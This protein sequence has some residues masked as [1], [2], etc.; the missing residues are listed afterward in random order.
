VEVKMIKDLRYGLRMLFKHKAFT[1]VAVLSLGLGIGANTAIFSLID[2]VLLKMLPV[3]APEQLFILN[4]TGPDGSNPRFSYPAFRRMSDALPESSSLSAISSL[5]RLNAS[6]AGGQSESVRGQLVSG[7]WFQSLGVGAS[8]GR[9]LE[10]ADN[11]SQ[12]GHPVAVLSHSFWQNR[13]ANDSSVV[14]LSIILNGSPFTVVGV[15]SPEFFG[16]S[17][18]EVPDLWIPLMMQSD[19]RYSQNA[20]IS[21][22]DIR[23]PWIN[24]NRIEWLTLILRTGDTES[25]MSL[26]ARLDSVLRPDLE[27][28]AARTPEG[29]GRE[30]LLQQQ[31]RMEPG[32]KGLAGLRQIFSSPLKVLMAMVGLVLL[33]ACANVANLSLARATARRQ[34]IAIR[35]SVGASRS[36]LVRQLLTESL[37]LAIIGGAVGLLIAQWG[38]D[39]LL[40]MAS[41]GQ[42]PI[43]IE[44]KLDYR[45]LLFAAVVSGATA[46]L[47]GLAPALRATRVELASAMK[48]NTRSG[49]G[50]RPKLGKILVVAQV[51]LSLVLLAG[52]ALF[53]RSLQNLARVDPGFDQHRVVT[54]RIDPRAAGYREEQLPGL[55]RRL[56]DR[57]ESINGIQLAT[58]SL[59]SPASGSART[60]GIN[61]AGRPNRPEDDNS[62]QENYVGPNYFQIVGMPIVRGR[63]FGP[64]DHEK[65]PKVAVVNETMVRQF[66]NDANPIGRRFGYDAPPLDSDYEIVGVVRDAKIN[67]L[68]E[69]VRPMIYYLLAQHPGEFVRGLDVRT[70]GDPRQVVDQIRPAIAEID[71]NLPVR[72]IMTLADQVDRTL[73][74]EKLLARL[75]GFFS[76]L[77]VGL[78]CIG[79]YGV[80]SYTV[81]RRTGEIGIRVALGASRLKVLWMVMREALILVAIGVA[82]GLP[83]ALAAAPMADTLVFGLEPSDPE[84]LMAASMAMLIVTAFS[85]YIPAWRASR[86]D[87]MIALRCE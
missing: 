49:G 21:D 75:T 59:Y 51:S 60:S 70:S 12:G 25:E 22:G 38:S 67:D 44:L 33:V 87:P 16:V 34:E 48:D 83:L 20:N 23:K 58:L 52:A 43:P 18:G 85:A 39:V 63:D 66:L 73:T 1:L 71:R 28:R 47:S 56:I 57:L 15:A 77:A 14:G 26:A 3:R 10:P 65:A 46:L 17:V 11:V 4:V 31:I 72:E 6:I 27:E 61:V 76:L 69:P 45:L 80:M 53:A 29:P 30:R 78:A 8:I 64:Q 36:R 42:N 24:Q 9:V 79:L 41:S 84:T 50:A 5:I 81:T 19:V 35:L 32:G 2:A 55:Y 62:A 86:V 82:A 54:A 40:Q 37:L 13:F 68:K 74:Q 7:E